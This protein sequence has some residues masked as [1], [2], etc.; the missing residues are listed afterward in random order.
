MAAVSRRARRLARPA[1]AALGLLLLLSAGTAATTRA[2]AQDVVAVDELAD[3]SELARIAAVT[4]VLDLSSPTPAVSGGALVFAGGRAAAA[5]AGA[6]PEGSPPASPEEA[7]A[8]YDAVQAQVEARLEQERA[9]AERVLDLARQA[10]R[11]IG[12]EG[13]GAAAAD[14][15]AAAAAD[16][17]SA[18]EVARAAAIAENP[19]RAHRC[20]TAHPSDSAR[21]EMDAAVRAHLEQAQSE[22]ESNGGSSDNTGG[23]TRRRL[24]RLLHR[25]LHSASDPF[26]VDFTP[27]PYAG[28]SPS[29]IAAAADR[30]R[31]NPAIVHTYFHVVSPSA[32]AG[33]KR[34]DVSDASLL[35]Q[36]KVLN[37]TYSS[38]GFQFRLEAVTRVISS[39][40]ATAEVA[41]DAERAMKKALRRGGR[42]ALN[43]YITSPPALLGWSSFPESARDD[44]EYDGVVIGFYTLPG[45][46]MKPYNMGMTMAH[47]VGHWLGLLHTFEGQACSGLGD[48]V[49]DVSFFFVFFGGVE[50]VV[51][52]GAFSATSLYLLR[53]LTPPCPSHLDPLSPNH[54]HN[55]K[56][57][58]TTSDAARGRAG[59]WLPCARVRRHVPVRPGRRQHEQLH[60]VHR[61]RVHVGLLAGAGRA[62]GRAVETVPRAAVGR[63]SG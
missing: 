57:P 22:L 24:R 4:T 36:M 46:T 51:F 34:G 55:H 49:G 1:T 27:D 23:G 13:D 7:D 54:N 59:L 40:F 43:I 14:A 44:R 33:P 29:A 18:E 52:C 53:L 47:E 17:P 58:T 38:A 21:D 63:R 35:A 50:I 26:D 11:R 3:P 5:A 61:R 48:R 15:E 12:G 10:N 30:A 62:H 25:A 20:T 37:A 2:R 60:A 56:T 19:W 9:D 28:L 39:S 41:S 6:P 32:T 31:R 8:A 16:A 42:D 45:S